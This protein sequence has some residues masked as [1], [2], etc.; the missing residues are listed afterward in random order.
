MDTRQIR[1]I[2]AA[3]G[4]VENLRVAAYC[5]V[6][7][8]RDAQQTSIKNQ[9]EHYTSFIES[10]PGWIMA[11]VYVDEGISGT[12]AETRPELQR[13]LAE[14]RGGRVDLVLT[15][16]IS[17]FA[18]NTTDCLEMVRLLTGLGIEI[19]FEKENIH[20]GTM[21][22]ELMLTLLAG[23]AEDESHSI[24]GNMKWAIRRRFADG[25]YKMGHTAYGYRVDKGVIS[26]QPEEAAVVKR[27]FQMA[28]SGDGMW[29]IAKVLNHEN[30]PAP[31]GGRWSSCSIRQIVRNPFYKGDLLCQKT[32]KDDHF[33]GKI[34]YGELDQYYIDG[35]HAALIPPEDFDRAQAAMDQR[36]KESGYRE[37][38]DRKHSSHKYP[39]SGVLRCASCGGKMFRHAKKG[40]TVTWI[41]KEHHEGNCPM[42]PQPEEDIK[43]AFINCLNKLSWSQGSRE[44]EER[45]LDVYEEMLDKGA[46]KKNESA[47]HT[48]EEKMAKNREEVGKLTAATMQ[49]GS[50]L[51]YRDKKAALAVEMDELLKEKERLSTAEAGLDDFRTFLS[52]WKITDDPAAFPEEAFTD[53]VGHCTVDSQR[54]AVFHFRCGLTLSESLEK[55]DCDW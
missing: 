23:F 26:I 50:T 49:A 51:P 42:L 9:R 35:H 24:S 3:A 10:H 54:K 22:S 7:T 40:Q 38:S 16:S 27:I 43:N 33:K 15:K 18:R 20:T 55:P 47:I 48:I 32:Y 52:A 13:L 53:F 12:K 45:I 14:C 28:L 19:Y 37:G 41:C 39:F 1:K 17:R 46:A 8:L 21:E 29:N 2:E 4:Q 30:I 6:S 34:N 11:G 36:A 5:R 31:Q 44:A 25:T